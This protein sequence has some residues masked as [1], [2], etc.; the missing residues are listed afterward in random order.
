[1]RPLGASV[2]RPAGR[3]GATARWTHRPGERIG[4]ANASARRTHRPAARP[5]R[6][7]AQPTSGGRHG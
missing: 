7:H 1:M 3:L 5:G 6:R 4:P 2:R